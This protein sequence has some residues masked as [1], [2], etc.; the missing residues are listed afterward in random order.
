MG[1]NDPCWCGSGKKYKRC[2][3]A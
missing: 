3:G 1:R 2:H